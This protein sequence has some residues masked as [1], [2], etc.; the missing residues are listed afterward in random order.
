MLHRE[1]GVVPTGWSPINLAHF[2]FE[3]SKTFCFPG[4][5][6]FFG[7]SLPSFSFRLGKS[8]R[9]K[10]SVSICKAHAFD[11]PEEPLSARAFPAKLCCVTASFRSFS[12]LR[13]IL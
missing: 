13:R 11:E 7:R 4:V 1:V 12:S 6:V 3:R 2:D 10:I 5:F 8:G 9:R